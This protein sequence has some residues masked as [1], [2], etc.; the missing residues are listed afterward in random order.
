M[1]ARGKG[2]DDRTE[3]DDDDI[4]IFENDDLDDS[5][6]E[7]TLD[8]SE[9]GTNNAAE[10]KP[11][12]ERVV[13]KFDISKRILVNERMAASSR[14]QKTNTDNDKKDTPEAP[15]P[16]NIIPEATGSMGAII[17]Q[18]KKKRTTEAGQNQIKA[19]EKPVAKTIKKIPIVELPTRAIKD[20]TITTETTPKQPSVSKEINDLQRQIISEIVAKDLAKFCKEA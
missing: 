19:P 20:I 12:P 16:K 1:S 11:K 2:Q 18:S 17:S 15:T 7:I 5:S 6:L 4:N 13:P 8:D 3:L 9:I 14:R 10:K